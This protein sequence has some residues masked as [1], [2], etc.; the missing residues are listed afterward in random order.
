VLHIYAI[1]CIL[2]KYGY[3]GTLIY[4]AGM[5]HSRPERRRGGGVEAGK[6]LHIIYNKKERE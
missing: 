6:F 1:L 5:F 3:I 2:H 4:V